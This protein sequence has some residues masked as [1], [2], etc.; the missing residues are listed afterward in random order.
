MVY[1]VRT[2]DTLA[3]WAA[4][5]VA[6]V[7][8]KPKAALKRPAAPPV[9]T[10]AK[11]KTLKRPA[12]LADLGDDP[13]GGMIGKRGSQ[14]LLRKLRAMENEGKPEPL[15]DY[16]QQRT[17]IAKRAWC[18]K[19]TL[20]EN[21]A[22][23]QVR[24]D[25]Q[26]SHNVKQGFT[27]GWCFLW[28]VAKLNGMVY[29]RKDSDQAHLLECLVDGC[30]S[31]APDSAKLKAEGHLQYYYI[32][33]GQRK[34]T[35]GWTKGINFRKEAEVDKSSFK[36][37]L[38]DMK[39]GMR[40]QLKL[41]MGGS[42]RSDNRGNQ[43]SGGKRTRLALKDKDI[44]QASSAALTHPNAQAPGEKGAWFRWAEK[45]VTFLE[46][47]KNYCNTAV[48]M[49]KQC[50]D[51]PWHSEKNEAVIQAEL[52]AYKAAIHKLQEIMIIHQA[53]LPEVFAGEKFEQVKKEMALLE[54]PAKWY[55][56][57]AVTQLMQFQN[58]LL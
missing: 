5:P 6:K 7:L 56:C 30:D 18:Q 24:E 38:D 32:K 47:R 27:E 14:D 21:C 8:A 26:A 34:T 16:M 9:T 20:D 29:N 13:E 43:I 23:L 2:L 50:N 46:G 22:F 19:F 25:N 35:D 12:A 28:D 41:R 4:M 45:E 10:L 58:I 51:K 1:S 15:A 44:A 11:P 55:Q 57:A 48:T 37:C 40:N 3:L 39:D 17:V 52:D 31:Q 33:A 36:T 54:D 42:D 53:A 49:Y